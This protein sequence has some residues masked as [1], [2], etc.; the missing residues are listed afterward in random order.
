MTQVACPLFVPLVEEGCTDD[1]ITRA[2]A[3]RYLKPLK[4]ARVDTVILGCTHYPLLKPTIARVLGPNVTLIDSARQ[5][6][7]KAKEMLEGLGLAAPAQ[8]GASPQ[9]RF[10]VTDEPRHFE[11]LARRF[12]GRRPGNVAKVDVTQ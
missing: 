9:R 8:N 10:F 5:V 12:L 2:V 4:A 1:A 3:Q 11:Q 7:L 6:A